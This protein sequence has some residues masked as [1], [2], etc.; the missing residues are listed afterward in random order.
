MSLIKKECG[1][2]REKRI[3]IALSD[4]EH[5]SLMN[6]ALKL[7]ITMSDLVRKKLFWE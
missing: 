1:R 2:R 4:D 6:E 3:R 5:A 7:D